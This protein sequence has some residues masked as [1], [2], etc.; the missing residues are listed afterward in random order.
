MKIKFCLGLFLLL[1]ITLSHAQYRQSGRSGGLSD[2]IYF[3]G[4]GGFSGGTQ[5]LNLSVSPLVGYK[6]TEQFSAGIQASYQYVRLS[7]WS[8]SNF[9]GGPFLRYFLTENLFT[10]AVY[11]YLNIGII[12]P[13]RNDFRMDFNSVLAGLGYALPLGNNWAIEGMFLYC[14]TQG[15]GT[16]SPYESPVIIRVG[17]VA[18]LF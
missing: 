8:A 16:R 2:K 1:G 3:G 12:D 9:G 14:L 15:D 18:G 11:E 10:I 5:Y 17:I 4:G 6:F 13:Q 7:S